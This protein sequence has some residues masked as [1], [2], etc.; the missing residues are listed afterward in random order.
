MTRTITHRPPHPYRPWLIALGCVLV[1]FAVIV[2][3]KPP[4]S[5]SS[6]PGDEPFVQ[7]SD[8]PGPAPEGMV[9]VPG[10]PFWMGSAEDPEGNAPV[11]QVAVSGFWMDRTEVTNA[12]FERVR[13]GD[14]VQD[15]G[16]EA[17]DGGRARRGGRADRP[18]RPV[19]GLLQGGGLAAGVVAV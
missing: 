5:S 7:R 6:S 9:W 4:R 2:L 13:E 19:L 14:G 10:G 1:G 8:P 12:Q 17:A 15:V 3:I 16:R 11:H 18:P